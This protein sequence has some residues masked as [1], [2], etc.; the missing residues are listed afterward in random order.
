MCIKLHD[1]GKILQNQSFIIMTV[2]PTVCW[3]SFMYLKLSQR[4]FF[5]RIEDTVICFRDCQTFT[6]CRSPVFFSYINL[7]ILQEEDFALSYH[8]FSQQSCCLLEKRTE[9]VFCFENHSYP[10]RE[11][12]VLVIAKNFKKFEAAETLQKF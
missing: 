8:Y 10:L 11:K 7:I 5:R 4:L 3:D 9:M 6:C 2:S 12:V 1:K